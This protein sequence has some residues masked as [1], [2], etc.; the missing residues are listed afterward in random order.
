VTSYKLKRRAF[1]QGCGGAAALLS[2][3]LRS[4]EARAQGVKAPLRLL[5]VHHP[6]GAAPGLGSW[7]P[8]ASATTTNFT[9]PFES[10]P[11]EAAG[12]KPYMSMID[13]LNVVFATR[14]PNANTGQNTHEGGMAT[15]MTGVPVL[16]KI[17]REDHAAGGA[18]IDQLLL[19]NSPLLGGPTRTDATPFSSLRLAA[20]VRSDRDEVAPRTLSYRPVVANQ[21][22]ISKARQPMAPDTQPLN[23]YGR[24]FGTAVPTWPRRNRCSTTCAAIS[25][26]CRRSSP[27]ARRIGWPRT[28]PRSASSRAPCSRPT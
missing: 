24:I 1:L 13:G 16:G 17:G 14:D 18:S 27:R 23:V 5:I 12:L 22:D 6:L 26:G 21:S 8:N 3:L 28:P 4:I 10:A 20:D 19:D 11:F 9:L 25:R 15:I 7:R 2:P